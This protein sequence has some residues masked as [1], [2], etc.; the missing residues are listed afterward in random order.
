MKNYLFLIAIQLFIGSQSF[1]EVSEVKGTQADLVTLL[2]Q[3]E[4]YNNC[5][6]AGYADETPPDGVYIDVSYVYVC[7]RDFLPPKKLVYFVRVL[8]EAFV[9]KK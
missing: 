4:E 8:D 5:T 6:F 9:L 3:D 7:S 1:A 2:L